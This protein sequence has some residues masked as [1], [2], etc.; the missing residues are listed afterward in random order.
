MVQSRLARR[1]IKKSK[2]QLY[3]SLFGIVIVL[4][5]A[6]NFGPGVI[7]TLG[8]IIDKVTGKTG[9]QEL[10]KSDANIQ[11][12][13]LDPIPA[14]TPSASITI[15]GKVDYQAGKVDLYVNGSLVDEVNIDNSQNF[16]FEN[17]N[18]FTGDNFI[19]TR[20]VVDNKKSDFSDE[21][22]ITYTKNAPKLD[23]S[24]PSDHQN[25]TKA[26][27]QITIKGVTDPENSVN[28]NGFT[29]IVDNNGN[30]SY[31]YHL[32][33]G[34]NKLTITATALSGQTITKEV[35]VSY[36]E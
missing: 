33:N 7:G 8:N 13:T 14:A 34:D 6:F 31:D 9:Q 17:V 32:T 3:A 18:L 28:V 19:K 11:P 1:A 30:F 10:V 36:S 23:I 20:L 26:D 35:T 4:F 24:F 16:K 29:A 15:T 27:L 25:F 12:P 22:K 5:I 2:N 21:K